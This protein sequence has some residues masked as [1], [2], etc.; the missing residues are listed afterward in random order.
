MYRRRMTS[1]LNRDENPYA[2][3]RNMALHK[4]SSDLGPDLV[5]DDTGVY[6]VIMDWGFGPVVATLVTYLTG[7]A[8]I[9]LSSGGGV[10]GGYAHE[11]VR[12][13]AIALVDEAKA[14]LEYFPEPQEFTLPTK[15]KVTFYVLRT[16][17][18][19]VVTVAEEQLASNR[20]PLSPL[21]S[22]AQ[23]A[24]HERQLTAGPPRPTLGS[25]G[26]PRWR[27]GNSKPWWRFWR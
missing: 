11:K 1:P 24:F 20:H 27:D 26:K 3:L 17:R 5:L 18:I 16:D 23:R 14:H 6:G 9:Y 19:G 22:A 25:A 15:G 2:G 4:S 8:S 7:D 12:Q 21:W 13:S 10:I